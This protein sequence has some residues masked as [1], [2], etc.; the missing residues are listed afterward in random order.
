MN[1]SDPLPDAGPTP[2]PVPAP[3][4]APIP[5]ETEPPREPVRTAA[6]TPG[7]SP[8]EPPAGLA[9]WLRGA[10]EHPAVALGGV[11]LTYAEL[12]AEINEAVDALHAEEGG[13]GPAD[14][15]A[16]SDTDPLT[17]LIACY[18]ALVAGRPVLISDPERPLPPVTALPAGAE[19]LLT[20]SGSTGR[21]RVIARTWQ[22]WRVSF[23]PLTE[24]TGID[25]DDSVALTGPLHGSMHLLAALHTLWVGATL[26]DDIAAATVL[27]CV[28]A[29][30]DTLLRDDEGAAPSV[31]LAVIGGA[32]LTTGL[33]DRARAAGI[34]LVEYYGAAELSF[35]AARRYRR[36][37]AP[38][39]GVEVQSRDGVI[40][41]RSPYL[42]LGYA[43]PPGA[44]RVDDDGF[45][46]VGDL[47]AFVGESL[48]VRGRGDAAITTSGATVLAED[49]E[50]S[51]LELPGVRAVAVVGLPHERL[52]EIVA[53]VMEVDPGT[54]G[55]QLRT[56]ARS[57]LQSAALPRRW[58]VATLPRTSAGKIARATIR[59]GLLD[60][61][62]DAQ[63]LA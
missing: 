6:T 13:G 55:A 26:T 4:P 10:L 38:F 18:A 3:I 63:P 61:T 57:R 47:G 32:P 46:S 19:L 31:R 44:L 45:A 7:E 11:T 22:S 8:V 49:I 36:P 15:L 56:E 1:P 58:Y 42:S 51:L 24:I 59:A 50:A 48:A 33:A 20:T 35:V 12:A 37:M 9:G 25:G 54:K 21:P 14:V 40:W 52:G 29:V 28:P 17:T 23:P 62:L 5:A 30:L 34:E 16:V 27:Q 39:P 41:A 43:G 60:G 2:A 53:A